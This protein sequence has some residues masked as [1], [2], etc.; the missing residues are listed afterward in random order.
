M[1]LPNK[2]RELVRYKKVKYDI[3][4][5]MT[6]YRE[7]FPEGIPKD[8]DLLLKKFNEKRKE[9]DSIRKKQF[10]DYSRN[11]LRLFGDDSIELVDCTTMKFSSQ[12]LV[13]AAIGRAVKGHYTITLDDD[14]SLSY[15]CMYRWPHLFI[16]WTRV[17]LPEFLLCSPELPINNWDSGSATYDPNSPP[18]EVNRANNYKETSDGILD[19]ITNIAY[20]FNKRLPMTY[21]EDVLNW[22]LLS[23]AKGSRYRNLLKDIKWASSP[24]H[25]DWSPII[26]WDSTSF[27]L[28]QYTVDF[29]FKLD[30][31]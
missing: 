25:S 17:N 15:D 6:F 20:I 23:S 19:Y 11:L 5:L 31:E 1:V 3:I 30:K 26:P 2:Y 4:R 16:G 21:Y 29:L 27:L 7:L 10:E 13:E 24:D 14:L 22:C 28:K 9:M 18:W 8:D 12:K